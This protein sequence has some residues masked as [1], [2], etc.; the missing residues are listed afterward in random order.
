M[1]RPLC[2][3][4]R[5]RMSHRSIHASLR[6]HFFV[7]DDVVRRLTAHLPHN[8]QLQSQQVT[9]STDVC[10]A[11]DVCVSSLQLKSLRWSSF[12][13]L[14]LSLV[15]VANVDC[16]LRLGQHAP[17]HPCSVI[18]LKCQ[19]PAHT[20]RFRFPGSSIFKLRNQMLYT[21]RKRGP[22]SFVGSLLRRLALER[23]RALLPV[24]NLG[25][26]R[27]FSADYTRCSPFATPEN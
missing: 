9:C 19:S 6:A 10:N 14:S 12:Y 21:S 16:C 3:C 24:F 20:G 2:L 22:N 5:L 4:R 13:R 18:R 11:C 7:V 1:R 27:F 23:A 25:H 17:R 26:W 8:T 15:P